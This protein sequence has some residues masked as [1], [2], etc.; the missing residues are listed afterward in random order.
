MNIMCDFM[1]C[2]WYRW[3]MKENNYYFKIEILL[4]RFIIV[5]VILLGLVI[6]ENK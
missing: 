5:Y 4:K 1:K 6:E 2:F 3:Y